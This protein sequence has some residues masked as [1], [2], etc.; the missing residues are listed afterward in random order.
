MFGFE[1]LGCIYWHM[2][3]KVLLAA[4]ELT[5]DA[6]DKA[7]S[8][9]D[10]LKKFYYEVRKGIGFNKNP[11]VYGAFPADPYS[12][13]PSHSGAQ[14]PGMTGQVKE[15]VLT[16]YGELG[17]RISKGTMKIQ[18]RLLRKSEFLLKPKTFEIVDLKGNIRHKQ[19]KASQLGFTYCQCP[20]IYTIGS[21]LTISI[22]STKGETKVDG[23]VLPADW[24]EKLWKRSGEITEINVTIPADLL[25]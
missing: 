8:S 2:V 11:A 10:D 14:Q 9:M 19:L 16:R 1:G 25:I 3:S 7:S 15:E 5:Y 21:A 17:I 12:H 6:V 20:F 13:T 18:P 22:T 4:Q 23:D 24:C